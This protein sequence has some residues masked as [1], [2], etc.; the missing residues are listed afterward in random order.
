[1]ATLVNICKVMALV[2]ICFMCTAIGVF[3]LQVRSASLNLIAEEKVVFNAQVKAWSNR[4]DLTWK[5]VDYLILKLGLTADNAN[6]ASKKELDTLDNLNAQL[7]STVANTNKTLTTTNDAIAHISTDSSKLMN[8]GN[9]TVL[10]LKARL[11][12]LQKTTQASTDA[13]TSLN[14]LISNPDIPAT[15]NNAKTTTNKLSE[16]VGNFDDMVID[17]K[18]V[19][20]KFLHPTWPRQVWGFVTGKGIAIA[21]YVVK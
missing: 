16:T 15:I 3:V 14:T 9:D 7:T 5:N 12:D 10:E 6:K 17:T 18:G 11:Q 2:A 8:S 21:P 13:I 1:M 19:W 20:H 4:A